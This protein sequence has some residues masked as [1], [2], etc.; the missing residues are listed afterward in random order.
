M[1]LEL[2]VV[3]EGLIYQEQGRGGIS[4][5]FSEM[6]PRMC[7]QELALQVTLLTSGRLRQLPLVHR[8][9]HHRRLLSE[10][11]FSTTTDFPRAG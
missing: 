3:I 8:R 6:L 5:L 7:E 9:I 11:T 2:E 10:M 4:R 1:S